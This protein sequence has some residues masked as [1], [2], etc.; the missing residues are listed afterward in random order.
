MLTDFFAKVTDDP[1]LQK[2][3]F[4]TRSLADVADIAAEYG[5]SV[6]GAE[7]V[8]AQADRISTLN[9][10]EH[11][12][13]AEGKCSRFAAQWGREGTGYLD[14]AGAWLIGLAHANSDHPD[15]AITGFLQMAANDPAV[16][17]KMRRAH[18][19][20]D[21]AKVARGLGFE[22]S[23][24]DLLSHQIGIIRESDNVIADKIARGELPVGEQDS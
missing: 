7:L 10:A 16:R 21:A 12:L 20:N 5:F 17:E 19:L 11:E 22:L 9:A 14:R 1:A 8:L 3:L 4:S 6:T 23:G 13:L 24:T 15:G 18:T 2:R